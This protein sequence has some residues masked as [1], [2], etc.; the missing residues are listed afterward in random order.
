MLKSA[1]LY[2]DQLKQLF[3][4]ISH[5]DKFKYLRNCSYMDEY[6]PTESTWNNHEFVSVINGQVIGYINYDI[7]R[8]SYHVS[9][10][11]LVNFTLRPNY[12]FA[13]DIKTVF[14]NIFEKYGFNKIKFTCIVGN[15]VESS[16]D[17]LIKKYNGRIVGVFKN[18]CRLMDGKYYDLK[19]YEIL[20]EDYLK[21]K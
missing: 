18:D 9:G 1:Q 15:P 11:A 19:N 2:T 14:K 17:K 8:D 21:G 7:N 3:I 4:K 5:D 10:I 6:K 16:Y 20:K 13:K 12:I